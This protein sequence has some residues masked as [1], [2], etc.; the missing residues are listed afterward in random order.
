VQVPNRT[1]IRRPEVP[2]K[3]PGILLVIT[4]P[5]EPCFGRF[6]EEFVHGSEQGRRIDRF[7]HQ[8]V[9]PRGQGGLVLVGHPSDDD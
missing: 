5:A 3:V 8:G 9:H 6:S 2:R 1:G 7:F 4:Y